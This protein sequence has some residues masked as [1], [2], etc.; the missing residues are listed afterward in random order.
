MP[1]YHRMDAKIFNDMWST[2][3]NKVDTLLL[4]GTLCEGCRKTARSAR[5]SYLPDLAGNIHKICG[6]CLSKGLGYMRKLQGEGM[7]E[8]DAR[9]RSWREVLGVEFSPLV[10]KAADEAVSMQLNIFGGDE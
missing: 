8:G 6:E 7:S 10:R 3:S 1:S 4:A 2:A 9:S 5:I